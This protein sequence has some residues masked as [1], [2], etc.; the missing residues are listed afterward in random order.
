MSQT[1]ESV[2]TKKR[3]GDVKVV[4]EI[5][6]VSCEHVRRLDDRGVMPKSIRLGRSIRWDLNAIEKWIADGC[7]DLSKQRS[8]R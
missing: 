7:P 1:L 3:L 5:M 6:S 8:R 4:K 2:A